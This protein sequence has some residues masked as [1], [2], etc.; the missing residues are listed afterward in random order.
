ME[1]EGTEGIGNSDDSAQ[2]PV[3]TDLNEA[4][5]VAAENIHQIVSMSEQLSAQLRAPLQSILESRDEL[6]RSFAKHAESLERM[7]RLYARSFAE[8]AEEVSVQQRSIQA[9]FSSLNTIPLEDFAH[10]L[11][12]SRT[13][14]SKVFS[15]LLDI[16]RSLEGVDISAL[17]KALQEELQERRED[18]EEPATEE[19]VSA[20][21]I[22]IFFGA[23][24]R[25][26]SGTISNDAIITIIFMVI[27]TVYQVQS[28][29]DDAKRRLDEIQEIKKVIQERHSPSPEDSA[30]EFTVT[31][32]LNL[33]TNP[34]TDAP[35]EMVIGYNQVVEVVERHQEWAYVKFY[36]NVEGIPRL[37]WVHTKYLD[38]A[39]GQEE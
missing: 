3:E 1:E 26:P 29:S 2:F 11:E 33:R 39:E 12:T 27:L 22:Q 32:D 24:Q 35:V 38:R 30:Q 18:I 10:Q 19:S 5:R 13:Q 28:S 31:T 15:S 37:G 6:Q 7:N 21:I 17:R 4:A 14:F 23:F 20:F 16:A 36:D 25:L 8:V 9:A 34:S